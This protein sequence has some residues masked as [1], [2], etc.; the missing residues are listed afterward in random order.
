MLDDNNDDDKFEWEYLDR[1]VFSEIRHP[2]SKLHLF[3]VD[4]K[5][6]L[7]INGRIMISCAEDIMRIMESESCVKINVG[8]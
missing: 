1:F 5:M 7:A 3:V 8:F 2:L 4:N 6:H